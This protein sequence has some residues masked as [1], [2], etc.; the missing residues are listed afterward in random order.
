MVL[1]ADTVTYSAD[2]LDNRTVFVA[3]FFSEVG[4][5]HV[6]DIGERIERKIP[7]AGKY[8]FAGDAL[9]G[10]SG[11]I[12]Q[13]GKFFEREADIFACALHF[14]CRRIKGDA[15]ELQLQR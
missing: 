10:V 1:T 6:Y 3:Q 13:E 8:L 2:R 4:Y 11:Q 12:F 5:M 14:F 9:V 7:D 15:A